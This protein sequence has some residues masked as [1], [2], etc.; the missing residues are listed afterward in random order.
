M[1]FGGSVIVGGENGIIGDFKMK[2][3][4]LQ[5]RRRSSRIEP[6]GINIVFYPMPEQF[7]GSKLA[8]I[9][10]IS[11]F[12]QLIFTIIVIKVI[13][14]VIQIGNK[15]VVVVM[16][17]FKLDQTLGR[18]PDDTKIIDERAVGLDFADRIN[19]KTADKYRKQK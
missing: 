16:L 8:F 19:C 17:Q 18:A 9:F 15:L 13:N 1:A 10:G 7:E 3:A 12:Y 2:F 14:N 11:Y 4:V 6:D 5:Q